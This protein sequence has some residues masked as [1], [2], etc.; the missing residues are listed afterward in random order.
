MTW[1]RRAIIL[2]GLGYGDEGKGTWTDF[3]A[4][5]E[6]VH[7]VVR[8][9][10]GAQ[11]GHNVVLPDG[12]HH[13]F[14]Q[15]GSGMLV[16][17]VNTHLS[18]FMLIDPFRLLHEDAELRALRVEDALARLTI[19]RQALVTT[20]FQ[21]AANRVR[22]LARGAGRHGSC[23]MGS[24][25]TMADWLAHGPTM[26]V[27]GDFLQPAILREKLHLVRD[28]K[29][30][31]LADLLD[32]LPESATVQERQVLAD[33]AILNACV[34][35]Y[36][37]LASRVRL[38]D[39]S[40]LGE[41]LDLAGT[42]VFEGAQGV[43]LDEW[44]GFHPYTTWSTTTFKNALTLLVEHGYNAAIL[45]IGLLRAYMTRH[46][47]GPFVGADSDLGGAF[48]DPYNVLNPWQGEFRVGTFDVVA[49]RYAIEV[50]GRPDLL[51]IS[52]LDQWAASPSRRMVVAYRYQ[53]SD[54]DVQR[55]VDVEDGLIVR[56][57]P[58][59]SAEDLGYQ[60]HLTRIVQH[61]EPVYRAVPADPDADLDAIEAE[62]GVP[63]GL[64]SSGPTWQDKSVLRPW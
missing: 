12:R 46:G 41:L 55:Y 45:K 52:H 10:G 51:A 26:I 40:Y 21:I 3:L 60:E 39:G 9:N 32:A 63:I 37:R 58:S 48:V 33:E 30:Q 27:A 64:V 42:V 18:R 35:V 34:N 24:G 59:P 4:R 49:A 6:P 50:A 17:G 44:H 28:L 54:P 11:A 1:D 38:V 20:P 25:E 62:L 16:Q 47:A 2:T 36:T 56:L 15:F 7:T 14:A 57:H 53:G 29:R 22:E 31:Q 61:C 5:T 19:D 8:F 43:L 23:G 13:T